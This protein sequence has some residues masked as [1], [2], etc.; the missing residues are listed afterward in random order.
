[1]HLSKVLI[2]VL[3]TLSPALSPATAQTATDTSGSLEGRVMTTAGE[4]ARDATVA[5]LELGLVT[6]VDEEGRF[7]FADLPL[8]T[9][10]LDVRSTRHGQ[11]VEPVE[12]A[13]AAPTEISLVV[14]LAVHSDEIV[15]STT[16]DPRHA[17]QLFQ[18]VGVLS[19][20]ELVEKLEMS[21]G[22]TLAKQPGVSS[23][24]FGPGAG[25]PIIRGL[26]G[27]RVRV[28]KDGLGSGD[29]SDTS[30]DHAVSIDPLS[31][32]RVEIARGPATLLY[33]SAAIGG[34]VNILTNSVPETLPSSSIT[35]DVA[36]RGGS[37]ANERSGS[38]KLDGSAGSRVAWHAEAFARQTDDYDI[39]SDAVLGGPEEGH[40]EEEHEGEEHEDEEHGDE[41][42]RSPGFLPNSSIESSGATLGFS[43]VG[44]RSF[45]GIA[46]TGYDTD[47][48]VPG[49][50]H[51]HGHEGEEEHHEGEEEHEGEEHEDEEH[52]GEEEEED[53]R[54]DLRQRRIDL[55]GGWKELGGFVDR[56]QLR[57]GAT[58]YE[59]MELEGDEIGTTFTNETLE[60]R[61]EAVQ[62]R[63]GPW[64]GSFGIQFGDR[65]FAAIG[66]EAFT[67]PSTTEKWALFAFEELDKETWRFQAGA[68]LESQD[69]EAE[70]NPSRSDT[71]FSG[72]LGAIW[73]PAETHSV[74]INVASSAKLPNAEELYSFGPHLATGTFEIGNPDLDT[75]RS[76]G[77]DLRLRGDWDRWGGTISAFYNDFSD[78]I[79][80]GLTGE[81]EDGLDVGRYVQSDAEFLGV[82]AE[83]HIELLEL[84]PHHLELDLMGD[85]VRAELADGDNLPRMPAARLGGG[86]RYRSE[87][88]SASATVTHNLE[89]DR[90]SEAEGEAPTPSSTLVGASVGYRFFTTGTVHRVEL[91]G[92]NLTDEVAR[93]ATSFLKDEIVLPGRNITLNYRLS[94]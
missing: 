39:P 80:L 72:S 53:I 43:W 58:D 86:L 3:T 74:S 66:E 50:G 94:F 89:Q 48:G 24:Y 76:L 83:V 69:V 92:T 59:H 36:L 78:Y 11:A 47:Y 17:S 54:I 41:E 13:S 9:F 87:R 6:E 33:G 29:A 82:E 51:A 28:L 42:D 32:E 55:K 85:V 38:L 19:G 45:F 88:W 34:A 2:V 27:D 5:I 25:R 79:Y 18:P 7:S 77:I 21:I 63:T 70:D 23:S 73:A 81:E 14:D 84:D 31:A 57:I 56:L 35:G 4:P 26:G 90:V 61:L 65:D 93:V 8:G 16:A 49:V 71:A 30:P 91:V 68:R 20:E 46:A 75:E 15:V 67:P 60:A 44:D 10:Y 40:E 12:I 64:H 1:M 62:K 37:V 22:D 52:E